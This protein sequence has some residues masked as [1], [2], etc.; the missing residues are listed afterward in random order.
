MSVSLARRQN[1]WS[2]QGANSSVLKRIMAHTTEAPPSATPAYVG[3]AGALSF[4]FSLFFLKIGGYAGSPELAACIV[5]AVY[6]LTVGVVEKIYG[7]NLDNMRGDTAGAS[8][9][10]TWAKLIG[11]LGSAFLV[12]LLYWLFPEYH[13]EF[14]ASYFSTLWRVAPIILLLAVPYI[15]FVDARMN[16]PFDGY[17]HFGMLLTARFGVVDLE[18]VKQL[19]LAW[20]V[21]GFFLPLMFTY[22]CKDMSAL[23]KPD[24]YHFGTFGDAVSAS[25]DFL[26][27][28]DVAVATAG[29]IFSLRIIGAHVRSCEPTILGWCV[30]L[31]CYQPFFS[32]IGDQ[33]LDY[34]SDRN[35]RDWLESLPLLFYAWGFIIVALVF[36][37]VW[38]T[39]VFGLRF[40][41]LT[42]RGIIA[43][44]P[45]RW[46]KHPA[47]IAKNIS[48][49]MVSMPFL[50]DAGPAEALRHSLLL[51]CLNAIY[52]LRARTEERHLSTDAAYR[53]YSDWIAQNGL[54]AKMRSSLVRGS[55]NGSL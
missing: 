53:A 42:N 17:W 41:N 16:D 46:T 28:V 32:L 31:V 20:L 34:G 49:W 12:G 10:R 24:G 26:Y 4:C 45:Y 21:K 33:Y 36:I 55:E 43:S 11:F 5:I 37:Y 18:K 19:L 35:W 15:Y 13:G 47:Y 3:V 25:M 29:Y 40:S 30:A 6:S 22:L 44:G 27:M 48:W 50:S 51:L 1:L 9:A 54:V 8:F 52:F 7:E 2:P 38:S 14:Y 39:V 23:F